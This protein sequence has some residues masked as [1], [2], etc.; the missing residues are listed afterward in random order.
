M[1]KIS[2]NGKT[3]R[4]GK[5]FLKDTRGERWELISP[6]NR[7]LKGYFVAKFWHSNTEFIIFKAR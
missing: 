5:N 2:I 3:A 1:K 6:T 4:E 7:H